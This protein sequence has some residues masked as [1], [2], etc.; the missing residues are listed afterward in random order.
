MSAEMPCEA[1]P[2]GDE[3]I[4]DG[5]AHWLADYPSAE[6]RLKSL[7]RYFLP[8]GGRYVLLDIDGAGRRGD[9]LALVFRDVGEGVPHG[10]S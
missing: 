8:S 10:M 7:T 5:T 6:S 1:K 9:H 3:W 2:S 4:L